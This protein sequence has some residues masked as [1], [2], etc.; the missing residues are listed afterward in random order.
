MYMGFECYQRFLT[1]VQQHSIGILEESSRDSEI[2]AR[3]LVQR[4]AA[5][6]GERSASEMSF[7]LLFGA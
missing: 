3:L 1:P 2:L 6:S 5:V 7:S 4:I